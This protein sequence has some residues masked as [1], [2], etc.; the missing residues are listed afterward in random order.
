MADGTTKPVAEIEAGDVVLAADPE[1][2]EQGPHVVTKLWVHEDSVLD[3][4]L[5]DGS[6]I[7]TTED[8]S[9]WNATDQR[10]EQIQQFDPGDRLGTPTGRTIAVRA[11]V[12]PTMQIE[13]AYNLTV[14]DL[15]TYYVLAGPSPVLVHNTGPGCGSLDDILATEHGK[16]RLAERGFDNVDIALI[17]GSATAYEQLDGAIAHVAQVGEN[18]FNV[19]ITGEGGIVTAMKGLTQRELDNLARNYGWTGYP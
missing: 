18:S 4:E 1:T 11:L 3:L 8:H 10:W 16:E 5:E 14:A 17:R 15:H 7:T 2:G 12:W 6:R 19:I 9:Y 13:T